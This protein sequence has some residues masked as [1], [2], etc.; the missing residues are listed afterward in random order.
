MRGDVL[1]ADPQVDPFSNGPPP[2]TDAGFLTNVVGT[3]GRWGSPAPLYNV[4]RPGCPTDK[5]T[6][7]TGTTPAPVP[8]DETGPAR[9]IP[10]GYRDAL[11]RKLD[12]M[13]ERDLRTSR[14]PSGWTPLAM[15][16]HLAFMERRWLREAAAASIHRTT[17]P[18]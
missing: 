13:S 18:P 2:V 5:T 6:R 12:G 3:S 9:E 11:L 10:G 1:E 17:T 15:L 14:L 16:K 7:R 4:I 8:R